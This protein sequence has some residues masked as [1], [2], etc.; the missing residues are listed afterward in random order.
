MEFELRLIL[1]QIH[2]SLQSGAISALVNG[3]ESK[4]GYT[5]LHLAA[6]KGYLVHKNNF[7]P[8]SHFPLSPP[9]PSQGCIMILL[10]DPQ[11]NPDLLTFSG[12]TAFGLSSSTDCQLLLST[13]SKYTSLVQASLSL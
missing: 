6:S 12:E 4:E 13:K 9:P 1:V 7:T 3:Q 5:P 8:V 11:I 2:S 10:S